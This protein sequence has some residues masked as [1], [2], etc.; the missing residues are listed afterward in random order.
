[1]SEG[2]AISKKIVKIAFSQVFMIR[3]RNVPAGASRIVVADLDLSG[4]IPKLINRKVV[5]ESPDRSCTGEPN[6]FYD[7]DTKTDL[8]LL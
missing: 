4:E 2:V 7:N 5:F 6:D 8:H 3:Y 1:M